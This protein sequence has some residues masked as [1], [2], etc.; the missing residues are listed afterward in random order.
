MT[1][2]MR[3]AARPLLSQLDLELDDAPEA[4]AASA[5]PLAAALLPAAAAVATS[6]PPDRG[7]PH[8]GAEALAEHGPDRVSGVHPLDPAARRRAEVAALE[9]GL[10]AR[11]PSAW[12]IGVAPRGYVRGTPAWELGGAWPFWVTSSREAYAHARTQGAPVLHGGEWLALVEAARRGRASHR[13][14]IRWLAA[15]RADG[16]WTLELGGAVGVP[17]EQAPLERVLSVADVLR[18]YAAELVLVAA[19]AAPSAEEWAALPLPPAAR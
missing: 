2:Q 7:E 4:F 13:E 10:L 19:D 8:A 17:L 11:M 3:R 9:A 12:T 15:K 14:L 1:R 6:G 5:P 18:A 16:S